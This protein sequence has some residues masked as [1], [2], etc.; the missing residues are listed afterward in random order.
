MMPA[1][2]GYHNIQKTTLEINKLAANLANIR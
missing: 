1:V 2:V